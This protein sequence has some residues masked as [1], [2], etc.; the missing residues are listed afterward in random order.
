MGQTFSEILSSYFT[1][2]E[3]AGFG[4][5]A[6]I[7]AVFF[8]AW[9]R[10]TP[11]LT[12]FAATGIAGIAAG[13][14]ARLYWVALNP[15]ASQDW[16]AVNAGFSSFGAI[17]GG[18]VAVAALR[19][20]L[21]ES[22]REFRE[23]IDVIV[24]AGLVGL[25]WARLGCL[26]NSCDF[27]APT[28]LV[29]AI[30][31]HADS[32]VTHHHELI[33]LIPVDS[34]YSAP[35]HPLPIYLIFAAVIAV[36]ASGWIGRPAGL[37]GGVATL[38]YAVLRAAAETTRAPAAGTEIGPTTLGVFASIVLAA[39]ASAWIVHVLRTADPRDTGVVE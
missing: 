9:R 17:L 29:W 1:Q 16:W 25:A 27:G 34:F 31:Y 8:A 33:G 32:A 12:S 11:M 18:A 23:S 19:F 30:R 22:A 38:V 26:A 24:P 2:A 7:L 28:D 4:I 14:G 6:A 13:L 35:V 37:S 20:T 21:F 5:F 36:F 39:C 15:T 3:L 10:E